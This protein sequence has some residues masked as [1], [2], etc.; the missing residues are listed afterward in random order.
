M[1]SHRA[2]HGVNGA[3]SL[4]YTPSLTAGTRGGQNPESASVDERAAASASNGHQVEAL[5]VART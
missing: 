4:R 3:A 2:L 5:C 1:P